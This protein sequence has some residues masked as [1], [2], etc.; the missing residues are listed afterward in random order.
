MPEQPKLQLASNMMR[1]A[2]FVAR[3]MQMPVPIE[4]EIVERA[5]A[6][7]GPAFSFLIVHDSITVECPDGE[8]PLAMR[9]MG[10]VT[11]EVLAER[12]Q[13]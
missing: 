1:Q 5:S 10:D 6:R 7:L 8:Q 12:M 3:I 2:D 11:Q 4:A 13:G 9:V